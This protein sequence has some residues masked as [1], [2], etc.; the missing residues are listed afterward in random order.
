MSLFNYPVLVAA[1]FPAYCASGP[2]KVVQLLVGENLGSWI[3]REVFTIR[4]RV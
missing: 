4:E 1:E 3:I 2:G